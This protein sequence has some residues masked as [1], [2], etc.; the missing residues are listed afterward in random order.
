MKKLLGNA[1]LKIYNHAT[2]EVLN[3][4]ELQDEFEYVVTG[5]LANN[6]VDNRF[7]HAILKVYGSDGEAFQNKV[8]SY[9]YIEYPP[10]KVIMTRNNIVLTTSDIALRNYK[11]I[12][13][14]GPRG[15]CFEVAINHYISGL[16]K[17]KRL[18]YVVL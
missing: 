15:G 13:F 6:L 5:F 1:D 4:P 17:R 11:E 7:R 2:S 10:M 18:R 12:S 16:R 9:E 8:K 14:V 3:I